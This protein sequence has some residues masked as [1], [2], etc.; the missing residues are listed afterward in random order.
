MPGLP[1]DERRGII[2]N[3]HGR[4]TGG[5][6]QPIAGAYVAGWIKRGATGT[7]GTNKHCALETV[8]SIMADF[9]SGKLA[10]PEC[11]RSSLQNLLMER[12]P[13]LISKAG[14]NAIDQAERRRG[15]AAGRPRVKFT[16]LGE[17]VDLAKGS[18]R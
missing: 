11:D 4:V 2:P 5:D 14:W 7:I 9:T 12:Q 17:M 10:Q 13:D 1:F 15:Q 8:D 6:G 18:R 3:D 16:D